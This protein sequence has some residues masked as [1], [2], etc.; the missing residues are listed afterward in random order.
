MQN[1]TKKQLKR[2]RVALIF[3]SKKR[4]N[5]IVK[6]NIF[7]SVGKNFFFQP[8]FIPSDPE[9]ITFHDNVVVASNV[10]FITHDIAH[11]MLNNLGLGTFNYNAGCIEVMN[12]VFI[13]SN[14]TILPNVRIGSNVIIAANAVVTKDIA[15]NSV[16]AGVP[17]KVI[18]T[19][20]NYLE[21]R[22]N[23][24]F[25][26]TDN[27]WQNFYNQRNINNENK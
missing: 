1:Y 20:D 2:L 18:E 24:I 7:K 10:T 11:N 5:Y 13:G 4:T 26:N 25:L 3:E 8:R 21:K 17:A 16:V 6:H 22:K 9:L 14:V 23:T 27:A 15:D 19:F 12:N